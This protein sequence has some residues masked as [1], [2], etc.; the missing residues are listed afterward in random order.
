LRRT[1]YQRG[2]VFL[3][4]RTDRWYFRWRERVNGKVCRRA[5]FVGTLKQYPNET[6]ALR[7]AEPL[8]A[9]MNREDTPGERPSVT[10]REVAAQYT[11]D[12]MP[13]RFSTRAAYTNNLE[14]HILPK[15]GERPI[16]SLRPMEVE[17]WLKGLVFA[18]KTKAHL[19]N[20]LRLLINS[21]MRRGYIDIARN[22]MELVRILGVTK[23]KRPRVLTMVEF[24][25][26]LAGIP[27]EPFRTM[28]LLA[29]CLGLRSC[30]VVGLQWGDADWD[31]KALHIR[32]NVVNGRVGDVKTDRSEATVPLAP[33]VAELLQRW[34]RV[35]L[36][37]KET[38]WVFASPFT[39]GA[40][41]YLARGIQQRHIRPAMDNAGLDPEMGWHTFRHTYRTLLST[42][43]AAL[44]VQRDL[45]RHAS[46]TTTMDVYGGTLPEP[47]RAANAAVVSMIPLQ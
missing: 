1:R 2:S 24:A 16:A 31:A 29:Q 27:G 11:A 30:E 43:G 4:E 35:T 23:R 25:K 41:P 28:V 20:M 3:D 15:W 5:V 45:M 36:F 44:D 46:I 21:A 10:V 19:R 18:P 39:G 14:N 7:A 13:Q 34:K 47:L 33:A 9:R 32:R 17:D 42:T 6:R 12:E 8:R 40:L 26:V 38:D 37:S 22:P